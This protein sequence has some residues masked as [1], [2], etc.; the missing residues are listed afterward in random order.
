MPLCKINENNDYPIKR[1]H[2]PS[3]HSWI[4]L[5]LEEIIFLPKNEFISTKRCK[6]ID[7]IFKWVTKVMSI[8]FNS[9]YFIEEVQIPLDQI[10]EIKITD[11]NMLEISL[12]P[13]SEGK[14]TSSVI[15]NDPTGGRMND[16]TTLILVP[17]Q[18]VHPTTIT[19]FYIGIQKFRLNKSPTFQKNVTNVIH[20][21]L[22]NNDKC[23]MEETFNPL[24]EQN[25]ECNMIQT[26]IM[27]IIESFEYKNVYGDFI[28]VE[29]EEDWK[30]AK[31][32]R[33]IVDKMRI[34][35]RVSSR[36]HDGGG[37]SLEDHY[38]ISDMFLL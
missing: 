26:R 31:V 1:K 36:G 33:D 18:K 2:I 22:P 6:H 11:K 14:I 28:T 30:I 15:D 29:C 19:I 17:C 5:D 21:V 37:G 10:V 3:F 38:I 23:L 25:S 20:D 34:I 27:T 7:L 8:G 24:Y 13:N 9:S 12:C 32:D 16:T 35:I 4:R